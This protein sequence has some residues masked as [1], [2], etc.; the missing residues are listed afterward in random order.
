M[1]T[2]NHLLVL[3]V[4]MGGAIGTTFAA[5]LGL[6]GKDGEIGLMTEANPIKQLQLPFITSERITLSGW[7]ID[8]RDLYQIA[9]TLGIV[10][11]KVLAKTRRF[12]STLKPRAGYTKKFNLKKWLQDESAEMKAYIERVQADNVIMVN[13]L[14]TEPSSIQGEGSIDWIGLHEISIDSPGV[15]LSRLYFRLAIELG[16]HYVNFTPNHAEIE[17]LCKMAEQKGILFCGKDG[18]SGQ[19]FLKT[20]IAPALMQRNFNIEGWY[21]LNLL[22]NKDGLALSNPDVSAT[23]QA[24]KSHC[25][26]EI[27]GYTPGKPDEKAYGHQVHI[28]YYPPRGDAKESWDNIDFNG[29]L[30]EGMQLKLNWLGKDSIL[31]APMILDLVRIMDIASRR[32]RSGP[33]EEL[34]VFFKSP[35]TLKRPCTHEFSRQ[36]DQL[37]NVLKQFTQTKPEGEAAEWLACVKACSSKGRNGLYMHASE[38]LQPHAARL[39]SALSSSNRY[40][41][42]EDEDMEKSDIYFANNNPLIEIKMGLVQSFKKLLDC[43][44]A[45]LA[46]LSGL[47]ATDL[48]ISGLVKPKEKVLA[49]SFQHGGHPSLEQIVESYGAMVHWLPF[50]NKHLID[51]PMLLNM[52]AN[53]QPSMVILDISDSLRAQ[54]LSFISKLPKDCI[55]VYDCSQTLGLVLGEALPN[56]LNVGF[57]LIISSTHKTF[58]GPHKALI[59][60]KRPE[61]GDQLEQTSLKKVSSDHTDHTL[62]LA[63]AL[64]EFMPIAKTY[65]KQCQLNARSFAAALTKYELDAVAEVPLDTHQVWIRFNSDDAAKHAFQDLESSGIYTN[66]RKLPFNYGWGLRIGVHEATLLGFKEADFDLLASLFRQAITDETDAKRINQEL[67]ALMNSLKP[68]MPDDSPLACHIK[69][70]FFEL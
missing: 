16:A 35:L 21:S 27:L 23:K 22:G 51:V 13:L 8:N 34:A 42:L 50:D 20:V 3:L 5:G 25:L 70:M 7:D 32:E 55:K 43:S 49:V 15:T 69:S 24:S 39:V 40:S 41:L 33:F 62:A 47:H 38:N 67:L 14:P 17:A 54:D 30:G 68:L 4:G 63:V 46:P 11:D 56:P 65:A 64:Y 19:T 29:Y 58:P 36:Y 44:W 37:V 66:L 12:L 2:T 61:L 1:K 57:D 26:E 52:V 60:T 53:L 28:H 18:K 45:S 31:A 48:C 10:P 59:A 9:S 6:A